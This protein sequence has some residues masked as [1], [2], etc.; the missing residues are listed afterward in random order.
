MRYVVHLWVTMSHVQWIG[1]SW[2]GLLNSAEDTSLASEDVEPL[3]HV[4]LIIPIFDPNGSGNQRSAAQIAA[5]RGHCIGILVSRANGETIDGTQIWDQDSVHPKRLLGLLLYARER[6]ATADRDHT[7]A[8]SSHDGD[9]YWQWNVIRNV[10]HWFV[11]SPWSANVSDTS[12]VVIIKSPRS[13][14]R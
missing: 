1:F 11:A 14:S 2:D 3:V 10:A 5:E 9:C 4:A 8:D 6:R 12:F 13:A 7:Q